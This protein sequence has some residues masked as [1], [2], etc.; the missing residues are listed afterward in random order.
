M[1]GAVTM[2]LKICTFIAAVTMIV[3]LLNS[4]ERGS[5]IGIVFDGFVLLTICL[6]AR[7][8]F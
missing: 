7:I 8:Y 5:G 3:K 2:V 4:A 6:L 1:K